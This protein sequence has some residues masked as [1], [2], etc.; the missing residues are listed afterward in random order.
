MNLCTNQL[1]ELVE[2]ILDK[3]KLVNEKEKKKKR[4]FLFTLIISRNWY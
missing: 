1:S 3:N 4:L 2:K